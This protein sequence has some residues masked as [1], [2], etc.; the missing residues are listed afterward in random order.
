MLT[1]PAQG[2][3]KNVAVPLLLWIIATKMW[4]SPSYHMM[5][6]LITGVAQYQHAKGVSQEVPTPAFAFCFD[7]LNGTKPHL[8]SLKVGWGRHGSIHKINWWINFSR[9][10]CIRKEKRC[11]RRNCQYNWHEVWRPHPQEAKEGWLKQATWEINLHYNRRG[12]T[13]NL[14]PPMITEI[15][16]EQRISCW[17]Y[18]PCF[19]NWNLKCL[20]Q[21]IVGHNLTYSIFFTERDICNKEE[22]LVKLFCIEKASTILHI[23]MNFP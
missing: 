16:D 3:H 1:S 2:R 22:L 20:G 15:A 7:Q 10:D 12:R 8:P 4:C 17:Y 18:T 9:K 11:G 23:I 14:L 21:I 13:R 19:K 5:R 6:L